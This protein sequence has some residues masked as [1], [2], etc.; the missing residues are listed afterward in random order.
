MSD[1]LPKGYVAQLLERAG[2]D[3]QEKVDKGEESPHFNPAAKKMSEKLRSDQLA[4]VIRKYNKANK[5]VKRNPN[6]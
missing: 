2:I 1:E 3:I 4:E 6:R 5:P